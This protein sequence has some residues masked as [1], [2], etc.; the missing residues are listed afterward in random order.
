MEVDII[1]LMVDLVL[2][3][4]LELSLLHTKGI[5]EV[6]FVMYAILNKNQIVLIEERDDPLEEFVNEE[7]LH[8][9]KK[10]NKSDNLKIGDAWDDETQAW[11][12]TEFPIPEESKPEAKPYQPTNTEIAQM[13]SDL[14][15]DLMIAGVI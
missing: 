7:F 3:V 2:L 6:V 1:P 15:A 4:A 11:V 8:M 14:Q 9:Y 13:I 10:I 5:K 12:I